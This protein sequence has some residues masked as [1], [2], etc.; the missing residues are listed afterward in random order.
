MRTSEVSKTLTLG[1]DARSR[2]NPL[3]DSSRRRDAAITNTARCRLGYATQGRM[4]GCHA[5]QQALSAA[6]CTDAHVGRLHAKLTLG[7]DE[8]TRPDPHT[9]SQHRRDEA[10][11]HNRSTKAWL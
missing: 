10:D 6:E 11:H 8:Q 1:R 5:W 4:R 9:H 7:R 2:P 3:P